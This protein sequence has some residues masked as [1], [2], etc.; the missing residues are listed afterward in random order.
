MVEKR[1]SESCCQ[2]APREQQ[3]MPSPGEEGSLRGGS[4]RAS[5]AHGQGTAGEQLLALRWAGR[6]MGQAEGGKMR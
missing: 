6:A 5:P 4:P 3:R 1:V 2:R